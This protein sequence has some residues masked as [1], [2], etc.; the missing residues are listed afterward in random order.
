MWALENEDETWRFVYKMNE[1]SVASVALKP[2]VYTRARVYVYTM[3]YEIA[4]FLVN[5]AI[6]PVVDINVI[7]YNRS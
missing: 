5:S 7:T 1:H 2:D 6:Y 4:L 3:W